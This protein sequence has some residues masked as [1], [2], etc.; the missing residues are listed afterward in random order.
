M[1]LEAVNQHAGHCIDMLKFGSLGIV[2]TAVLKKQS[3]CFHSL[4]NSPAKAQRRKRRFCFSLRLCAFAGESLFLIFCCGVTTTLANDRGLVTITMLTPGEVRIEAQSLSTSNS[5][6]FRNAYAGVLGIADRVKDFRA[7]TASEQDAR[8][9]KIA[10]GEFRAE[11]DARKI[12]YTVNVSQPTAADVS[13]VSWTV[14]DH[15]LLMLADLLPQDF[16]NVSVRFEL[17]PGWSI[18]SSNASV[19]SNFYHVAAPEKAIFFIGRSLRKTSKTVDEMS[20]TTVVGGTWPFKEKDALATAGKVL[21]KYA[22]LTGFKLPGESF[23]MI[24]PLPVKVGSIKWRAETRGSTV[25]LLV[26]S[27][28][29]FRNWIGQLGV[30]FTHELL[31]LWVPNRLNLA[32]DYDWFFEGFTLYTALRTALELKLIN[33]QEYLDTLAR[34]YDSYLSY[35]DDLSLIDASERR[36]TTPG[37][38]VYD[39]GML[40]AFLYDLQIRKESGRVANLA[41][42]YRELFNGRVAA[43]AEGNAVIIAWLDS[44]P[45]MSGFAKRLVESSV[46]LEL[47]QVLPAY[48]LSLDSSTEKSR[49]R[50]AGNLDAEQKLL[51]RS[52]G[53]RK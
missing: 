30:I 51:L 27:N 42:R 20:L 3:A 38:F 39:K 9:K 50:V 29:G 25:V 22:E 12:S 37:T 36:W 43:N 46:K 19:E 32:G 18:N 11:L 6:S 13:H 45:A 14:G 49:L 28:A 4:M 10:T 47:Q 34:V 21:K 5:W 23:I 48:G 44:A 26:D 1:D 52:L 53:Y 16:N 2:L 8:V 31:H 7:I 33:F 15:G 41:G 40:V 24:A 17:P 35:P